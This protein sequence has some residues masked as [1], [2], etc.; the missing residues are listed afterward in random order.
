MSEHPA[1]TMAAL[2]SVGGAIGFAKTRSL[3][4]LI[5]G[6]GVGALYAFAA[7]RIK[8]GGEYGYEIAAGASA[9]LMGSSAPRFRKGPVPMA[10]TA[11]SI[12]AL[13]YYGKKVY[14]FR[15]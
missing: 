6:V 9:L 8:N 15:Q 2:C 11:T 10:L 12:L 1:F 5:A 14:D 13:G 4:S 3:P 7:T